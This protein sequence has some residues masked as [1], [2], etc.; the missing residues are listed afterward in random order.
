MKLFVKG[1]TS[2]ASVL[3]AALLSSCGPSG[4]S[5]S[6]PNNSQQQQDKDGYECR[7]EATYSTSSA[8]VGPYGGSASSGQDVDLEMGAQCLRAR[9][10]TVTW[11]KQ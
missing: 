9:G 10:Y 6:R 7:R 2:S 3:V 8:Y 1:G 11:P 5:Y 4:F